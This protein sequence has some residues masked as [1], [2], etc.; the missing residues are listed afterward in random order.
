[1]ALAKVENGQKLP[2][3]SC[4]GELKVRSGSSGIFLKMDQSKGLGNNNFSDYSKVFLPK[5]YMSLWSS[6][7]HHY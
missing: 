2:N 5:H 4:P 6:K 7:V 3:V 1:M